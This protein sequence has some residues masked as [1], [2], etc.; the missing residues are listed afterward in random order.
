MTFRNVHEQAEP[1]RR[2]CVRETA[3]VSSGIALQHI[4]LEIVQRVNTESLVIILLVVSFFTRTVIEISH[5]FPNYRPQ[6]M[7][8]AFSQETTSICNRSVPLEEVDAE[9][10]NLS[11]KRPAE[12]A[13]DDASSSKKKI[14]HRRTALSWEQRYE[15]LKAYKQVNG[16]CLVPQKYATNQKLANWVANQRKG[17]RLY[18]KAREAGESNT[19][20]SSLGITEERILLLNGLSFAW[21]VQDSQAIWSQRYEELK[22]Y[23][24][25]NGDCLVPRAYAPNPRLAGW[26]GTQRARYRQFME[27]KKA[28]KSNTS[29]VG[30]TEEKILLLNGLGFAWSAKVSP[31]PW[32][33]RYEE[34]KAYKEEKGNCMVPTQYPGLGRWVGTQRSGYR[35]Y[36][37]AKADGQEALA[38]CMGMTKERIEML[39]NVNF[40]WFPSR[41][42]S[43]KHQDERKAINNP[44]GVDI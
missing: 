13:K 33:Q 17:Y 42:R 23:K 40:C 20:T 35:Q 1:Q 8:A 18:M 38:S 9:K 12:Q 25:E 44:A 39:N 30:M 4:H 41:Q 19:P 28:G 21:S 24:A 31:V 10:A 15:E 3:V 32:S 2:W 16:D 6:A 14:K 36:M 34:L 22:A 27:V 11:R 7:T 43:G 29:S 5:L 37:K 26:V